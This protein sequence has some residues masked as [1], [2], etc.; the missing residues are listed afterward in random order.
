MEMHAFGCRLRADEP[1]S[2]K[3][4]PIDQLDRLR[5]RKPDRSALLLFC[6][7]AQLLLPRAAVA[8]EAWSPPGKQPVEVAAGFFLSNLSGAAERSETFE[9]DLYL[10]FRWHDPRL[11]F[12]GTDP[13]RFLRGCRRRTAERDMVAAD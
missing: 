10:I 5:I 9:A 7:A 6:L 11:A 12:A 1:E 13:K 3:R 8:D 4:F 2:Q